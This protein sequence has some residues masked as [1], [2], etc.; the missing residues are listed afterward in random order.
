VQITSV[1][2]STINPAI[3]NTILAYGVFLGDSWMV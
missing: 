1:V 2:E 3:T